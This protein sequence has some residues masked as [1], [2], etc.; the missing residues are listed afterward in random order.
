ML[1]A[2]TSPVGRAGLR[3]GPRAL[4]RS[5][6]A[7]LVLVVTAIRVASLPLPG[8]DDV[9]TWK[10]W[11]YAAS[12]DLLGVYGVG[13]SPPEHRL[14]RYGAAST[15]TDY[16]PVA[17]AEMAVVGMIYRGLLPDFPNDWRLVV[18]VKM[19]GLLA[20]AALAWLLF[21]M[22]RRLTGNVAAAQ[23]AAL[24]YWANP[25]T[26]LN[27]EVLGYLDPLAMLPAVVAILCLH[28]Q[29][30][31]AAGVLAATAALT[32]PQ[33]LLIGPAFLLAA[34][35]TGRA[36]HLA[37]AAG[38]GALTVVL[39]ALPFVAAGAARNMLNAFQSWQGRRDIL[40]G[41]AAN[42]WWIAT[43]LERAYNMIPGWGFPGAYF[44]PVRRILAISSWME[45]GLPNPRPF[46]AVLVL[47]A[48]AWGAW[49]VRHR[50]EP[51]VHLAFSAFVVQSFFVWGVSVHEH[52]LMLAV[53]LLAAAAALEP[54]CRGVFIAVS[55]VAALNMNL[56]YGLG[57]GVGWAIPRT[58]TPIDLSVL[59][60]FAS[61]GVFFWHA[62]VLKDLGS[63]WGTTLPA[64]PPSAWTSRFQEFRNG[65][66]DPRG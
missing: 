19:P 2:E 22:T 53:P 9:P 27:G 37:R 63:A 6:F 4:G 48:I 66:Q 24:A 29:H 28:L 54:A 13:G 35:H 14:L 61:L 43:W 5:P 34:W 32:K 51:A 42:V 58:L 60:S 52:H 1:P 33:A 45:M 46:G 8:M 38:A 3:A 7:A 59:L 65:H 17:M 31:A 30:P 25:A 10:I 12:Q 11:S 18:A 44:E 26:I 64:A 49:T 41:Y 50:A 16:P 57:N 21:V 55:L 62:R 20:G 23:C 47:A 40:S 36:R 15:T 39:V 56:F